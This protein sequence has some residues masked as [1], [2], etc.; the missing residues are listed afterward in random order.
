VQGLV[1][2]FVAAIS[3]AIAGTGYFG[4]TFTLIESIL[5]GFIGLGFALFVIERTLRQR[6]QQR[7]ER[8]IQDLSRLLS[9]DAQA[10]KNLSFRLNELADL[11]PGPR[12]DILEADVSVLG[13]VV[14]ELAE[15]LAEI[16]ITHQKIADQQGGG[17]EVTPL[18]AQTPAKPLE[19]VIPREVLRQALAEDRLIHHIMPIITLPQRRTHGYDLVPRL[20]LEGEE[21]AEG[22]DFMPVS[23]GEDLVSQIEGMALMDAVTIARRSKTGGDPVTIYAPISGATMRDKQSRN[24]ML[25]ILDANRAVNK[26]I[27]FLLNEA[28]WEEIC[29]HEEKSVRAMVKNGIGFSLSDVKTL[30]LNY[31]ELAELGVRSVRANA[32]IFIDQPSRYTDFH[33]ADIAAYVN[34]FGVDLIMSDVTSEQQ[35][36]T[37]L[38]DGIGLAQGPY[39]AKPGPIRDDLHDPNS[40]QGQAGA[41]AR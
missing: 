37:L 4:L 2:V 40:S 25:A 30:R 14:R 10:G 22:P 33:T 9:T 20:Q 29:K 39:L 3:I 31:S 1:Y 24:Q 27:C 17:I 11:E 6:A 12:I 8:S 13:T 35:V 26:L 23:G 38:D 34:R 21:I 5:A 7:L 41:A 28:Q 32:R 36:L 19:P 15:S 18:E 16:E